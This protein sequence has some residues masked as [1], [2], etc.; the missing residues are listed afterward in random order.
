MKRFVT[1][2]INVSFTIFILSK[3]APDAGIV[4]FM[5]VGFLSA[6]GTNVYFA[7]GDIKAM[8]IYTEILAL[9]V[10]MKEIRNNPD[11]RDK[12]K[13]KLFDNSV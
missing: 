10:A 7:T 13:K 8:R 6:I 1:Q 12:L 11:L 3:L 4:E 5:V 2:I 9:T